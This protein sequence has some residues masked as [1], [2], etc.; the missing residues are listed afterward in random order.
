MWVFCIYIR[1]RIRC[2]MF[3]III[4]ITIN[5][6]HF[7]THKGR[8]G[9]SDTYFVPMYIIICIIVV[10]TWWKTFFAYIFFISDITTTFRVGT[11][12]RHIGW[13]KG[14]R[15]LD[16]LNLVDY[17]H[18]YIRFPVYTDVFIVHILR[19]AC[20]HMYLYVYLFIYIGTCTPG[21]HDKPTG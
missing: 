20:R 21:G 13:V 8:R 18:T 1:T 5:V 14:Y 10:K 2:Y 19:L 7:F 3:Y 12:A 17:I 4:I 6:W 9:Q 16:Q 15:Q 11:T